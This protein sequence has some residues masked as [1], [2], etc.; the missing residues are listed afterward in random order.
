MSL[1]T[2]NYSGV[3]DM[4]KDVKKKPSEKYDETR[5]LIN[6][7]LMS[8]DQALLSAGKRPQSGLLSRFSGQVPVGTSGASLGSPM[9]ATMDPVASTGDADR[10]WIISKESSGNPNAKNPKSSAFGLG[11]LI[12][13]NREAYAKR[14]GFSPDTVNPQEQLQMMDAYVKERY[15]SYAAARKFWEQHNWY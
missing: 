7:A 15:G 14:F 2:S 10:D 8:G 13:S 6:D 11:Q 12:R 9:A 4:F 5:Q 3:G 1:G